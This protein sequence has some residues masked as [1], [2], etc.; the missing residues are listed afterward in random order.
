[1]AKKGNKRRYWRRKKNFIMKNYFKMKFDMIERLGMDEND[2]KF[3]TWNSNYHDIVTILKGCTDWV[4]AAGLFHSFKLTGMVIT[5]TP[6]V[7]GDDFYCRGSPCIGLMT[8]T[9]NAN[10]QTLAESNNSIVLSYNETKRK[11][12]SF[13]GGETGWIGTD[14]NDLNGRIYADT[15]A[16]AQNGQF[17]WTIKFTFYCIFK[18]VS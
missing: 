17:I 4:A 5:A 9:E 11:Y 6:G 15:L 2:F 18:N 16:T 7:Y 13:H 1:M 10:F 8:S 12:I 3:M 14:T